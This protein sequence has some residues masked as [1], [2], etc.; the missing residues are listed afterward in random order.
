[1]S[2]RS[3]LVW[4]LM[5]SCLLATVALAAPIEPF[6]PASA[7]VQALELL[8][9]GSPLAAGALD[10]AAQCDETTPRSSIVTLSWR[11][12]AVDAASIHQVDITKFR[13]GF[14]LGRF[15]TSRELSRVTEAVAVS[16]PVPGLNYYW[17]IR[18][19]TGAGWVASEVARFEVPVC[20]RDGLESTL[21]QQLNGGATEPSEQT[22]QTDDKTDEVTP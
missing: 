2:P 17:R 19:K 6:S 3:P 4:L 12:G 16:G 8:P 15:E 1:M 10:V 22:E 13:D 18:T 11:S 20:P 14:T 5:G 21:L 7:D 9:S